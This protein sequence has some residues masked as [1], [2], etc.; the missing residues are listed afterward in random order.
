VS[1]H[2]LEDNGNYLGNLQSLAQRRECAN[3]ISWR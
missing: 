3:V 1:S 2:G